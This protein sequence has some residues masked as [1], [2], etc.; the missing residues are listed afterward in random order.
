MEREARV[1][2]LA[3]TSSVKR[4]TTTSESWSRAWALGAYSLGCWTMMYP[5]ET[6]G[7]VATTVYSS[8][9]KRAS[10]KGMVTM[11]L[12]IFLP[13]LVALGLCIYLHKLCSTQLDPL[14]PDFDLA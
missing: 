9:S 12:R 8:G 1:R 10:L 3:R 6:T 4:Q 14:M 11:P 2:I 13:R 7:P 5:P